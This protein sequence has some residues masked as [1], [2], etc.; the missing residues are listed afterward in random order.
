M[1]C[2]A[3]GAAELVRET[4]DVPF[5]YKGHTTII[6]SIRG[7]FCPA[8]GDSLSG[9]DEGERISRMARSF[10]AAVDRECK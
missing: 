7:K 4:R 2:P 3:C 1:N 6:T 5:S 10:I 8:C 9:R